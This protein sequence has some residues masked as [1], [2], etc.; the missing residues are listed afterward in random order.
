MSQTHPFKPIFD[1]N[2]KILILGSFPSAPLSQAG[3]LL[4]KSAKS[5]LARAG[6]NFKRAAA[7]E[8]GGKDKIPTR[9]RHRHLRRCDLLRDKG[10]E[11]RQNDRRRACEFRADL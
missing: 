10:F 9:P 11:R 5:L 4:R 2:S 3:L 1:E 6:A 7:C 8:H